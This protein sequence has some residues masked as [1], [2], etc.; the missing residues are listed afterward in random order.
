MESPSKDLTD[1]PES[2]PRLFIRTASTR[3]FSLGEKGGP[4]K[5]RFKEDHTVTLDTDDADDEEEEE[6][7]KFVPL[8]PSQKERPSSR[9]KLDESTSKLR[10]QSFVR[11]V[12]AMG[13]NQHCCS[14]IP[15]R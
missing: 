4:R 15:T 7:I 11:V 12:M 10:P 14:H 5:V 3:K 1:L 6:E 13:H 9:A 2:L 8:P